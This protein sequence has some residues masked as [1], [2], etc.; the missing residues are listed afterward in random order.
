M[1]EMTVDRKPDANETRR[2]VKRRRRAVGLSQTRLAVLAG[3]SVF[4]LYGAEGGKRA[5]RADELYRVDAVLAAYETT[6]RAIF[7]QLAASGTLAS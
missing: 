3:V 7:A 2:E 6:Q 5:L 4:S 1:I